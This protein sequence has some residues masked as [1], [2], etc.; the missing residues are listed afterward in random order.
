MTAAL[1]MGFERWLPDD[2]GAAADGP[3][4]LVEL[5]RGARSRLSTLPLP[6]TRHE[7]WRYTSLQSLRERGFVLGAA[8]D[9]TLSAGALEP[10]LIPGFE[11]HRAVLVDGRFVPELSSLA[12]L[13]QGARVGGLRAILGSDPDALRGR[14]ELFGGDRQ[15][16]FAVI[17][18]AGLDD[19]LVVLIE[20]GLV[21]DRPLELVHV[22]TAGAEP[23]LAQPR[24][25]IALE[26]GAQAALVERY[27]GLGTDIYCTNAVSE[28]LLGRDARLR[29]ERLQ[30]EGPAASHLTALHLLQETGSRYQ[31]VD[32]G[33]GG[34]WSRTELRARFRGEHAE[35][36]FQGLYLAGD[37]QL[38]DYH[39]DVEHAVPNCTSRETFK[40]ILHGKGRA[41]FDGRVLVAKDAQK[42]DAAM[43]NR[44]LMLSAGAEVDTKPQLE[45]NADDVKCSHGTTVGQIEPEKLFYLRSRGIAEPL[46]R[47][48]L[49]LGFAGE[50]IQALTA[51]S[52]REYV[53]SL[54]GERLEAAATD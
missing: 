37:R 45:I 16:L 14:L 42:T 2:A 6:T 32:I 7:D 54:V 35:C 31:G 52:V 24:H 27:L 17:N 46:A 8:G 30:T 25:L 18:T 10:L 5:R 20:R 26:S 21:L 28:I 33:I 19:G 41:V 22:S 1:P 43:S 51:E 15:G 50:I 47:R 48:M 44:N 11:S 49:C 13:P 3:D 29:H 39:L 23:A 9:R 36:D 4:W 34:T 53:E 12:G 40:G 38:V